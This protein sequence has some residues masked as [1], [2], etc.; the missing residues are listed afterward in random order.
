MFS[1]FS[2]SNCQQAPAEAGHLHAPCTCGFARY[3][4]P[5]CKAQ[6]WERV[7][8]EACPVLQQ[9]RLLTS[10]LEPPPANDDGGW[11]DYRRNQLMLASYLLGGSLPLDFQ[12]SI[13][14]GQQVCSY[15]FQ[16]KADLAVC[17]DC[18]AVA[19]CPEH[20]RQVL[21]GHHPVCDL[22]AANQR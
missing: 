15:C 4:S 22:L 14:W 3:C 21:Q 6:H 12:N 7:H 9:L 13:L 16:G 17:P 8:L 10:D 20:E 11:L 18:R 1:A 19:Y 2:C 5:E